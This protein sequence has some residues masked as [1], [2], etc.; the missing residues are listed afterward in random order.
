MQKVVVDLAVKS[1]AA[2]PLNRVFDREGGEWAEFVRSVALHGVLQPL[3]VRPVGKGHEILAGHRRAAAA[4]ECK[5]KEVPCIV[6]DLADAEALEFLLL[7]NLQR[8][9]LDPVEEAELVAAMMAAGRTAEEVAKRISRS[10]EWVTLR[11]GVLALGDEVRAALKVKRG[12]H[13]HLSVGAC[14]A[15]L[16]VPAEERVRAVQLVLHPDW[17]DEP[18][19]ARDADA[20]VRKLVLEPLRRKLAW[21]QGAA[22]LK[23]AWRDRLRMVLP[24]ASGADLAVV[25]GDWDEKRGGWDVDATKQ[26]PEAEATP[27]GLHKTWA[28]L[29]VRHGLAVR[30]L[31]TEEGGDPVVDGRLL[32]QAEEARAESGMETWLMCKQAPAAR[33]AAVK[34]AE[35]ALDGEA[36]PDYQT[37]E[38]L[39]EV[40]TPAGEDGVKIEQSFKHAVMIDMGE[41]K[42]LAMWAVS[43]DADPKEAPDFV[44]QWARACAFEGNWN[45]IDQVCNWVKGLKG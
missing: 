37:E 10:V 25:M 41:V 28:H 24:K 11:Q 26:L 23:K 7:E 22:T 13:G 18:L 2:H 9:D 3:V 5:Q 33:D 27:E 16:A 44:P 20:A 30:I 29:A 43:T 6:R 32:R 34:K 15:L 42:R 38:P 4:A 12:D 31:P 36:N 39:G 14:A 17:Q 45:T 1:L 21:E 40:A 19:G 8:C 35:A